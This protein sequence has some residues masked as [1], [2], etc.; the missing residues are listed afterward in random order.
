MALTRAEIEKLAP[1]SV[2]RKAAESAFYGDQFLETVVWKSA[3]ADNYM[4]N[5]TY[6]WNDYGDL[7]DAQDLAFGNE[8]DVRN[9]AV[10]QSTTKVKEFGDAYTINK[11][12]ARSVGS[13]YEAGQ[14]NQKTKIV[15]K[16]LAKRFLFG[17]GE[18]EQI[19]GMDAY[20]KELDRV[21]DKSL[22]VLST[23]KFTVTKA[24]EIVKYFN[25]LTAEM[26]VVPEVMYCHRSDLP[27]FETT[28]MLLSR[29]AAPIE[30]QKT[31]YKQFL[32][33]KIVPLDFD[34]FIGTDDAGNTTHS[35]YL[36]KWNEDDGIYGILPPDGKLLEVGLADLNDPAV[37]N[38]KGNV[39]CVCA[40][41]PYNK[42]AFIKGSII[43]AKA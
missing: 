6:S 36:C 14:V 38:P 32:G 31:M 39:A 22:E 4:G 41:V 21:A 13:D 2:E 11:M 24:Q 7:E 8:Y 42:R 5:G 35:I 28:Q 19:K 16:G 10:E 26:N 1:N 3:N 43:T 40:F 9:N 27:I 37:R 29:D 34:E 20:A 15:K 18:G 30:F 17:S 23:D 12:M 33:V 25:D